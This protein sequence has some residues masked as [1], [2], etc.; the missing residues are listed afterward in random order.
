VKKVK[1]MSKIKLKVYDSGFSQNGIVLTCLFRLC[2]SSGSSVCHSWGE[3]ACSMLITLSAPIA[4]RSR[5]CFSQH[6]IAS[7]ITLNPFTSLQ[8]DSDTNMSGITFNT[9]THPLWTESE[10]SWSKAPPVKFMDEALS[11]NISHERWRGY[12][13]TETL[14]LCHCWW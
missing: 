9:H 2:D 1:W 7:Q 6:A 8:L 14:Q 4:L 11:V 13:V 12:V 3:L 10:F 5:L